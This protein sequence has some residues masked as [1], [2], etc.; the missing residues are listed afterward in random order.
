MSQMGSMNRLELPG[1]KT[2]IM[3]GSTEQHKGETSLRIWILLCIF[4]ILAG[5][6][7]YDQFHQAHQR[8][9]R[10]MADEDQ[11]DY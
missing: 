3:P 8:I 9:D 1:R 5:L 4:L 2:K 11:M 6:L 10:K 7:V